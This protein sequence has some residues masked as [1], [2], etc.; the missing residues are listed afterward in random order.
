V[1][2]PFRLEEI[3]EA[4]ERALRESRLEKE[5]QRL[6]SRLQSSNRELKRRVQELN[7]LYGIGK[8]IASSL[9]IE[10]VLQRVVEAAVY[11]THGEEGFLMLLDE[12]SDELYMR[13]SKNLD[14][15]TRTMRLRVQDSLAGEVLRSQQPI[16][17]GDERQWQK[18]KTSYLVRSLVYVPLIINDRSIGILGVVNRTKN[19]SL[20]QRDTRV[21]GILA[22]YAAI[23]IHNANLYGAIEMRVGELGSTVQ[24]LQELEDMKDSFIQNVSHELRT[25]LAIIHGYAELLANG[26]LGEFRPEQYEPVQVIARRARTLIQLVENLTAFVTLRQ[27][28]QVRE[29]VDIGRLIEMVVA[30]F[31]VTARGRELHLLHQVNGERLTVDGDASH[32]RRVLDNLVGNAIKFTPSG[33]RVGVRATGVD[34]QV[35]VEIADT[36][37]GIDDDKLERIFERF[38]Q[39]E[40][41]MSRRYGGTGLGLALVK[42]IVEAHGGSVSV[43]SRKGVGSTFAIHLPATVAER[44]AING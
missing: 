23:A 40:G 32:L 39:V 25:P 37:I 6:V 43:T 8:T 35:V 24:R 30:D 9:D 26:E 5:R 13:A 27:Q 15:A 20:E 10:S 28:E 42:E 38:Y 7:T 19:A 14:S 29:P 34:H 4:I 11:L 16:V 12:A 33:G 3:S 36:G 18:I 2:K 41:G 1:V 31:Q 22:G 17:V 44:T 21:L